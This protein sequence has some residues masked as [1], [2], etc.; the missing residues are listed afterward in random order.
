[1]ILQPVSWRTA[2]TLEVFFE[3]NR[4]SDVFYDWLEFKTLVNCHKQGAANLAEAPPAA[5]RPPLIAAR[6]FTPPARLAI[7]SSAH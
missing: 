5:E 3:R 6:A 1:M 4:L 2:G 7:W